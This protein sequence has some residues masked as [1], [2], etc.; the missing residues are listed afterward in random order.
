MLTD[1]LYIIWDFDPV[2]FSVGSFDL[3][4]YG[5]AWALTIL[6]GE[7]FFSHFARREGFG[8]NLV[9]VGFI[10]IAFGAIIGAR[11]G[12][13]LFYEFSHYMANPLAIITEIRNG[14]MAS[15]GSAIGMLIGMWVT[16]RKTGTPY[17]WWLDRIMIPVSVGGTLVASPTCLGDSSS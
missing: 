4:Y 14:G 17:I 9:E 1:F 7:R 6:L 13:C 12:H 2:M 8:S 16:A 3:R 15:H 5:L 10:W 11:L